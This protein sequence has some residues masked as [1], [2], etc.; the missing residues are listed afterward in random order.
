MTIKNDVQK[1]FSKAKCAARGAHC[2]ES[3]LIT[4]YICS[5]AKS[6]LF[7]KIGGLA[8]QRAEIACLDYPF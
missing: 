8:C 5:I 3:E 1:T 6:P 7:V 2:A 4:N